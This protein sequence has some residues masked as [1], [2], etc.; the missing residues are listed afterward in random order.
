MCWDMKGRFLT[1]PLH[2]GE[3]KTHGCR[4]LGIVL[5][6]TS[7]IRLFIRQA[8]HPLAQVP[9]FP[10]FAPISELRLRCLEKSHPPRHSVSCPLTTH[11]CF[12][13]PVLESSCY[14]L[15]LTAYLSLA[16]PPDSRVICSEHNCSRT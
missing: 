3:W 6:N 7:V 14:L 4:R 1:F 9:L 2:R 12:V 5:A 16:S 10:G 11:S 15:A 8:N 13:P